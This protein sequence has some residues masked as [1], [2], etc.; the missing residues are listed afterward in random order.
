MQLKVLK[1][2]FFTK[3]IILNKAQLFFYLLKHIMWWYGGKCTQGIVLLRFQRTGRHWLD[4]NAHQAP[5]CW[6]H[7]PSSLPQY[8]NF[9][10][11]P[12]L[13]YA[14]P[15]LLLSA[16]GTGCFWSSLFS[17]AQ[18]DMAIFFF[19]IKRIWLQC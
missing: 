6:F 18:F 7:R 16:T 12:R 11:S 1:I 3:L 2:N 4:M 19:V 9:L 14:S 15:I 17:F 10:R 13:L 5:L 8:C